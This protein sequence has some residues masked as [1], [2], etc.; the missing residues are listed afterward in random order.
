MNEI[1]SLAEEMQGRGPNEVRSLLFAR[2]GAPARDGGSGLSIPKW[3]VCGGVLTFHPF[4]G[5][6]F[7]RGGT[8]RYL[9]RTR[10]PTASCL[11]GRYGMTTLPDASNRGTTYSLGGFLL[12]ED[13]TYQLENPLPNRPG[14]EENLFLRYPTG[15]AEVEYAPGV[16]GRTLL[17]NVPEE[18][19]IAAVAFAAEGGVARWVLSLVADRGKR[20][21]LF[22]RS[23]PLP[24]LLARGWA[25]R[26]D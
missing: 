7:A 1:D 20:T 24:F 22:E 15:T 12:Q 16:T 4:R 21:V 23:E 2:L 25:N 6:T 17:E 10:N 3:D 19:V 26:W 13:G 11:F 8:T 18:A 14:Q 5:P 9:M